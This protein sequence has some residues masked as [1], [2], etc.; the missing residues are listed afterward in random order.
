MSLNH[1]HAIVEDPV[2]R[3]ALFTSLIGGPKSGQRALRAM[4]GLRLQP[5]RVDCGQLPVGCVRMFRL[6]LVNWGPETAF[7][8]V[9]QPEKASGLQVTYTPGP[10]PA[11]LSRDLHIKVCVAA[12]SHSEQISNGTRHSIHWTDERVDSFDGGSPVNSDQRFFKYH[13]Q[14]YYRYA[15]HDHPRLWSNQVLNKLDNLS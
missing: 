12:E 6:R 9:K 11:G 4:R 14:T 3:K 8:R 15:Y 5:S 13:I 7:F 1:K 10:I 2:R